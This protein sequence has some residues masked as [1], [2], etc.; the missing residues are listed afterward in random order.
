MR[1]DLELLGFEQHHY[2][3][4]PGYGT[5]YVTGKHL[6]ER[7]LGER[8]EQLG[9]DFTLARYFAELNA[10]GVIPMSLVRWQLTGH[11]D[12]IQAIMRTGQ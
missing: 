3:R 5:C 11:D 2:L 12:E 4:Q 1:E 10:A 7:L 8:A 9:D 6:V